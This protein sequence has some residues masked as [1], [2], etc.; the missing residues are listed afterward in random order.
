MGL[1]HQYGRFV[2]QIEAIHTYFLSILKET[3]VFCVP[4]PNMHGIQF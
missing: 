1:K 4:N 2:V 3:Y